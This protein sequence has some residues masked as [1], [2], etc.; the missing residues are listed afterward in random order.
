MCL[1]VW[2]V[3]VHVCIVID[4]KQENLWKFAKIRIKNK[5]KCAQSYIDV[6][7]AFS[8]DCSLLAYCCSWSIM[9]VPIMRIPGISTMN[10]RVAWHPVMATII[11]VIIEV[12]ALQPF[13]INYVHQYTHIHSTLIPFHN[14]EIARFNFNKSRITFENML[15][16]L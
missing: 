6:T 10:N 14:M 9:S 1:C 15:Q 13:P 2:S 3:C 5:W 7:L 4:I 12:S 16:F 8:Y 11:S